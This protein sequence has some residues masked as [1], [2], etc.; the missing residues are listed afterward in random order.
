MYALNIFCKVY[1]IDIYA[2]RCA[3]DVH[4]CGEPCEL[5]GRKGCLGECTKVWIHPVTYHNLLI[6]PLQLSAH[7]DD[8]HVCS[9]R[10]HAC[11]EVRYPKVIVTVI[12]PPLAL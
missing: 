1:Y 7:A 3:V 12:K 8:E 10:V 5:R 4:L 9:A 6:T 11:G 2:F